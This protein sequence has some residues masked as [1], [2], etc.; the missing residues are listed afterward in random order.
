MPYLDYNAST[1][2]D[3]RVLGVVMRVL[4]EVPGN[5]SSL[6][7][8]AGQAAAEEVERARHRVA[9]LVGAAPAE[10]VFT[11]GASEALSL[12]VLGAAL[13]ERSRPDVVV[14]ATEHKATFAAARAAT[15]VSGGQVHVAPV[16]SSG[17]VDLGVLANLVT[18]S[19]SVVAVMHGN[20]ETGVLNPVVEAAAVAHREGAWFLCDLTQSA[21][22]ADVSRASS[23]ADLAV[24][25]SHK[26]YG[27]KGAGALVAPRAVQK[28]LVPIFEGGGQERGL[29]GGTHDTA[30]IAG[31]GAAADLAADTWAADA[32][33][34]ADLTTRLLESV[35][36]MIPD[37]E[38][39]GEHAPRLPNTL[40]LRFR[41][42]DA[43][44]VMASAPS[45]MVSTG[46]ACQAATPQPSHVLLAMGLSHAEAG[47]CLRFSVGRP[48]TQA[49][50]D[51][52]VDMLVQA[53]VRVRAMTAA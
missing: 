48:T 34:Y 22:K 12:A 26:M 9:A 16:H 47:E 3:P 1:P 14:A 39:V 13:A 4:T 7:H 42:A 37:V 11:S 24:M 41:G 53:V 38:L 28:R 27:P 51:E 32:V 5:A 2:L 52:T 40:N 19:T 46:S 18:S 17:M 31:F 36:A 49:E 21:G 43:E 15:R 23:V 30:S 44:A 20:N 50:V 6:Q 45:L 33:R 35:T 8:T 25:S 29:R 10:V